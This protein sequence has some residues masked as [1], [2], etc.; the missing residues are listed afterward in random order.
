MYPAAKGLQSKLVALSAA[1]SAAAAYGLQGSRPGAAA[2][3]GAT[4]AAHVAIL[5]YTLRA[6]MPL[7]DRLLPEGAVEKAEDDAGIRRLLQRVRGR[8]RLGG[9]E[10]RRDCAVAP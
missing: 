2:A 9:F 5:G 3:F 1:A 8:R 4:A 10:S 6:I 7:N